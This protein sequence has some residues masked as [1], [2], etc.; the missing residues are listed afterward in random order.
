MLKKLLKTEIQFFCLNLKLKCNKMNLIGNHNKDILTLCKHTGPN[1]FLA[2]GSV[3]TDKFN[4]E[5]DVDLIVDF[6]LLDVLDFGDNYYKLKFSL[7][8]ILKRSV[9]LLEEKAIK[10][11]YFGKSLKSK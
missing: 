11:P 8:Y 10:N 3:I 9:E 6:G 1:L 2:F 4:R 7:K 5:S